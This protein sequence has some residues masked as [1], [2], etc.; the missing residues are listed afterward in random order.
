MGNKDPDIF[1]FAFQYICIVKVI[2]DINV[3]EL[4]YGTCPSQ[5]ADRPSM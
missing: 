2:F 4:N 3:V 1:R 5:E